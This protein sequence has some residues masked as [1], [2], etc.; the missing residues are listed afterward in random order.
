MGAFDDGIRKLT[1]ALENQAS[2]A[3]RQQNEDEANQAAV[4]TTALINS[5]KYQGM[6][7]KEQ[8]A[9]VDDIANRDP[10]YKKMFGKTPSR[11]GA[12][13]VVADKA[14]SDAM[15]TIESA[16]D[17]DSKSPSVIRNELGELRSLIMDGLQDDPA[18][19][20]R[21]S[22]NI[23]AHGKALTA[24]H[25]VANEQYTATELA[26]KLPKLIAGNAKLFNGANGSKVALKNAGIALNKSIDTS[27]GELS[28]RGFQAMISDVATNLETPAAINAILERDD[29]T[30]ATVNKL[31]RVKQSL[32]KVEKVELS[33]ADLERHAKFMKEFENRDDPVLSPT[34]KDYIK[35]ALK[36][37]LLTKSGAVKLLKGAGTGIDR[38]AMGLKDDAIVN[39]ATLIA[40]YNDP[41]T[42]MK[43]KKAT[44]NEL[45]K[46]A[47]TSE[48]KGELADIAL[49]NVRHE[50]ITE[51][52]ESAV[53]ATVD[54]LVH[55]GASNATL[56][57]VVGLI[58]DGNSEIMDLM[59]K[60]LD[61]EDEKF[62][63]SKFLDN[64]GDINQGSMEVFYGAI[65]ANR[66]Q[67]QQ[68]APERRAAKEEKLTAMRADIS[69]YLPE[70][71]KLDD[72]AK[73]LIAKDL[74][75]A[76]RGSVDPQD[77]MLK[78]VAAKRAGK[79]YT[80]ANGV[81]TTYKGTKSGR[82]Y[83]DE[84]SWLMHKAGSKFG[85]SEEQMPG[86]L[87]NTNTWNRSGVDTTEM[88]I[89]GMG[90]KD[91]KRVFKVQGSNKGVLN[92]RTVTIPLREA[93]MKSLHKIQNK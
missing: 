36:S 8:K 17:F 23:D 69:P 41:N 21:A 51:A 56:G 91:G 31:K 86:L 57:S 15:Q 48:L 93:Y 5:D 82:T 84:V 58:K 24:K 75:R 2:R 67:Q 45:T 30:L 50:G 90:Y 35:G 32:T 87:M 59:S 61:S 18:A 19:Q 89:L 42:P 13:N 88:E 63:L 1:G 6:L 70:S 9:A 77:D 33:L 78:S 80:K 43:A 37:G 22:K 47:N 29:L 60:S 72:A 38:R 55:G 27:K 49:A 79:L 53:K 34:D 73:A 68:V 25:A 71:E 44:F 40:N 65:R 11:D 4:D 52:N 54:Q 7:K 85:V 92:G 74:G 3:Y 62:Q 66:A 46:R 12:H 76:A 10:W 20:L 39:K 83:A 16:D 28:D 14:V 64:P 81:K 26:H